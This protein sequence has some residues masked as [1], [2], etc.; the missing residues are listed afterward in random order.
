MNQNILQQEGIAKNSTSI[1][2]RWELRNF[3]SIQDFET[4]DLKPLTIFSGPNSSG[5]SVIIKSLLMVAQSLDSSVWEVPLVLNGKYTQLGDFDH[6]LHHGSE[7]SEIELCFRIKRQEREIDVQV[8]IKNEESMR[9]KKNTITIYPDPEQPNKS[10]TWFKL[11]H[12][13]QI[14]GN[15]ENQEASQI[16]KEQIK[17]GLFNYK[18]INPENIENHPYEKAVSASLSNFLPGR[19]LTQVAS[20]IR[21]ITEEFEQVRQ[22]I[23]SLLHKTTVES[24]D[25]DKE[26][27]EEATSVF[28]Q[29]SKHIHLKNEDR[30]WNRYKNMV[31]GIWDAK[32]P[33]TIR[34]LKEYIES[35]LTIIENRIRLLNR[36]LIEDLARRMSSALSEL[37][38]GYRTTTDAETSLEVGEFPSKYG[39]VIQQIRR[40][41][42]NQIFYLGPLRDAPRTIYAI[43]PLPNQRDVGLKGE[44]TAAMLNVHHQLPINYPLPPPEKFKGRYSIKSGKLGDA[45]QVWLERMGL[46]ESFKAEMISKR[47]S[48]NS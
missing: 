48:E 21:D 16:V 13:P 44:Y 2:G 24:V 43:P 18:M 40:V 12:D 17:H 20:K 23:L 34:S 29:V 37:H 31:D 46:A 27:S 36:G 1:I 28:F 10:E 32:V 41:F 47:P 5:K 22:G 39:E 30:D 11:E 6:I 25:W 35:H 45:V 38:S 7:P 33:W 4:L 26:L 9:V 8:L 15:T 14:L 42:G 19:P 3:Q